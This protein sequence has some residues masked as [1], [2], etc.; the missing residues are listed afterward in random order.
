MRK[1]F[2]PLPL[3]VQCFFDALQNNI[4]KTNTM[5]RRSLHLK[6]DPTDV[7]LI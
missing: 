7:F 2:F 6:T 1:D 3:G 4:K 5:F